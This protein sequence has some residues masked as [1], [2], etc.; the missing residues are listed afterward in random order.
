MSDY[1]DR[2]KQLRDVKP[3]LGAHENVHHNVSFRKAIDYIEKLENV[4]DRMSDRIDELGKQQLPRELF[5][6]FEV[7]KNLNDKDINEY[8][9]IEIV[10]SVLDTVVMM[11]RARLK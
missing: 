2:L 8:S 3:T 4:L 9:P 5:N 11:I 6:G 10:N 1:L 7:Y